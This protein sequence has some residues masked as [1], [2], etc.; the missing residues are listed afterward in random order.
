MLRQI[1]AME[2]LEA[3][4][5]N[6]R[7]NSDG[8][9]MTTPT[10]IEGVEAGPVDPWSQLRHVLR[11]PQPGEIQTQG[12]L[13]KV[14]CDA[15]GMTFV[16]RLAD[17]VIKLRAAKFQDVDLTS[18]SQDAGREITCGARKPESS[19]VVNYTDSADAHAK[20]DGRAISLEFVPPDFKLKP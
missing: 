10:G 8:Q 14:D 6:G 3:N 17:R 1:A 16:I 11:K 13:E 18:F 7:R 2:E 12:I 5:R 4:F 19:V 9:V 20:S 15:K